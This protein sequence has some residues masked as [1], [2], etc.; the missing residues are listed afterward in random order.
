LAT[1]VL[2]AVRR[3]REN[4]SLAAWFAHGDAAA[5]AELA[6]ASPVIEAL[7]RSVVDDPLAAPA[8]SPT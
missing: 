7:G 3:V 2:A 6:Q 8:R 5:T 4:P 1:A